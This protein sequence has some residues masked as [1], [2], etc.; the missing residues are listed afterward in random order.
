MGKRIHGILLAAGF[1]QRFKGNKLLYLLNGKELYL[2][3]TERLEIL[4]KNGVLDS[5]VLVTQYD[6]ILQEMKKRRIEAIKNENS[7]QGI[8]SSL[9]L[10]LCKA[11]EFEG[12]EDENYYIFFVADQPYL[13]KQTIERFLKDFMQ[14]GKTIGCVK[15]GEEI[16][17]PV[18]FHEKYK[19]KL[20]HLQGDKGGKCVLRKHE[21][22]VFYFEVEDKKELQ[23]IDE[24]GE[25]P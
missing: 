11:Q 5:L 14:S 16:G 6:E 12:K 4:L 8:S 21:K 2:Y 3:L 23:D 19:E 25:L 9:K 13:K 1:S 18:I 7:R 10:G 15:A 24:R 17:N 20:E 22:E